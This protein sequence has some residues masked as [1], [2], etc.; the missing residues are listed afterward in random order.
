LEWIAMQGDSLKRFVV[1]IA[2]IALLS[3][4][5]VGTQLSDFG[6]GSTQSSGE[7]VAPSMAPSAVPPAPSAGG[8]NQ[9]LTKESDITIK[10]PT[11]TLEAKFN[12][13]KAMLADAGAQTSGLTY[14]ELSDRK[15][16]TLTV[17]IPPAKFDAVNEQLKSV[18]E[19]TDISVNLADVTK[20][21]NDLDTRINSS[22][23]ELDR[24][25]LLYNRSNNISDLLQVEQE[26]TRVET[27][28]QLLQSE[29]QDLVSRIDLSTISVTIYE[30]K[31]AT[32]QVGP[33]LDSLGSLFFGALVV[34][35]S[36]VVALGGFLLPIAVVVIALWLIYK[37]IRGNPSRPRKPEHDQIPPPR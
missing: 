8:S 31:P 2:L 5:C 25:Y 24:L 4:G 32:Q 36:L 18:G 3:F 13:T 16:Y 34:A 19:V 15:E 35:I 6:G 26:I 30:E 20:Q 22:E 23:I 17:K 1:L 7:A 37:A 11:G 29:K 33:S 9:L 10:V 27:D 28:L 14:T 12:A 21:Y